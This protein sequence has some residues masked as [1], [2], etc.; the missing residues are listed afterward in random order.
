MRRHLT[1]YLLA[2][3]ALACAKQN[4]PQDLEV[5]RI[6]VHS[7]IAGSA[8]YI[9]DEEGFFRDEGIRLQ[10][11][12]TTRSTQALPVLERGDID[13]IIGAVSVGLYSALAKGAHARMVADRAYL[14]PS[15][16]AVSAIMGSRDA[17]PDDS[18]TAKQL[19]GKR[20][21]ISPASTV[22]YIMDTYLKSFGLTLNDLNL[23]KLSESD[24][25]HAL[26]TNALDGM[27]V[28]EPFL[29]LLRGK[30]QRVLAV[31]SRV[32]PRAHTSILIYGPS[33]LNRPALA[34]RFMN[35]YLRGSRRYSKGAT[36]RNI[37]II[38]KRLGYDT[39]MLRNICLPKTR[40][41][42]ELNLDWL[43]AFQTWAVENG[44]LER[45]LGRE[46][47]VDLSFARR[48]AAKLD[49]EGVGRR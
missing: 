8:L 1:L 40:T 24:E 37:E 25:V 35:A 6:A 9:A 43:L 22:A 15:G 33:M 7:R 14:D 36:P 2:F 48:A 49:A 30:G 28:S 45:V 46:A 38:S 21:S 4:E 17:F 19:R 3:A 12:E 31:T 18:P 44:H 23:V 13:A 47:G 34:Q 26:E 16:C 27:H 41:D 20:F 39:A 5:V 11:V 32:A 42:G 29:S 10:F